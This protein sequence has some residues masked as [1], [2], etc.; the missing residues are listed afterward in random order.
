VFVNQCLYLL[1]EQTQLLE[2]CTFR[3]HLLHALAISS[4]R[5]FNNV[6]GKEHQGGCFPFTINAL[7]YI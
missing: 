6:H 5:F 4:H 3:C 2:F 1:S 7:E